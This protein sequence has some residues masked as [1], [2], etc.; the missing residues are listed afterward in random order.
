MSVFVDAVVKKA[1]HYIY[2]PKKEEI[3]RVFE[4][5]RRLLR[6]TEKA[7]QFSVL[8]AHPNLGVLMLLLKSLSPF[9][10]GVFD[11]CILIGVTNKNAPLSTS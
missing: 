3:L 1:S 7:L 8:Y 11:Q 10:H 2:M 5:Y 4:D 9:L 6:I